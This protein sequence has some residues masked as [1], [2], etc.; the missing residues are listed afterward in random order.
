[1]LGFPKPF[2][3]RII[4]LLL[5]IILRIIDI[6]TMHLL[7]TVLPKC[8]VTL[9]STQ[10]ACRSLNACKQTLRVGEIGNF[11]RNNFA[12]HERFSLFTRPCH[13]LTSRVTELIARLFR[14]YE[15]FLPLNFTGRALK[16]P[17]VY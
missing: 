14:R 13:V 11:T 16:E 12:R 9:A 1:M 3:I 7:R 15:L 5:T 10:L 17:S 2:H 6:R 8:N 4:I